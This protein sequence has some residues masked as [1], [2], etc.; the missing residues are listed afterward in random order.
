[1]KNVFL[2]LI[3]FTSI[4]NQAQTFGEIG[5]P[6]I[7][8]WS[9]K[10][11]EAHSQNWAI[12][13]DNRGIMYIGNS[14]GV[15]EFDGVSWRLLDYGESS[16][17]RSLAID[18]S[19][20]IFVGGKNEIGYFLPVNVFIKSNDGKNK[21]EKPFISLLKHIPQEYREFRDVWKTAITSKGVF[22]QTD[23][24]LFR[25]I[26]G[27]VKYEEG[28]IFVWQSKTGFAGMN[29]VDDRIYIA[30][31]GVGLMEVKGDSLELIRGGEKMESEIEFM[32]PISKSNVN[33]KILIGTVS[34]GLF[35]YDGIDCIPLEGEA[36]SF[37]KELKITSGLLLSDGTIAISTQ[38]C[39]I[40]IFDPVSGNIRN[41]FNK[42]SGLRDDVVHYLFTDRD[43]G[44]WAAHNSGIARLEVPSPF[45]F[46]DETHGLKGSPNVFLRYKNTL[47]IGTEIGL[48]YLNLY[49]KEFPGDAQYIGKNITLPQ[50]QF[51]PVTGLKNWVW[52]ITHVPGTNELLA[53]NGNDLYRIRGDKAEL[54]ISYTENIMTLHCSNKDPN[55][56]YIGLR[57]G[58]LATARFNPVNNTCL[59][60]GKI[61]GIDEYIKDIE[62]TE[63]GSLW[64]SAKYEK[65]LI[66]VKFLQM[67]SQTKQRDLSKPQIRRFGQA[68]GL[69]DLK[70]VYSIEINGQ[71]Y[72]YPGSVIYRF[73]NYKN[74]FILDST[75][76]ATPD[77]SVYIEIITE[78]KLG[79]IWFEFDRLLHVSKRKEDGSYKIESA[80]FRRIDRQVFMSIYPDNNG[81]I[82]YGDSDALIR[83]D[84]RVIKNYKEDVSAL[85]RRVIAG[86]DSI[87]FDGLPIVNEEV[88]SRLPFTYNTLLFKYSLPN[89]DNYKSNQYQY[90][91]EGFDSDWSSWTKATEKEYTN[92][93]QG[94][95]KFHVRGKNTY[96]FVSRES[97]YSFTIL[98]PWYLSWWA[99]TFYVLAI[100]LGIF[101]IDRIMRRKIINRERDRA[102]LRE[103]ELIKR[104]ADELEIVDR[105]VK[106]I[107]RAENLDQLFNSLLEQTFIVIPQGEK[108]AVFLLNKKEN[109][110]NI[111]Y[112]EGYE[113]KDLEKIAFTSE[114]LKT[115]YTKNSEEVEKGIYIIRNTD[116]LFGNDILFDFGKAKS[117]LVMAV[118]IDNLIE[119]YV[120]FDNYTE[121]NAFDSSTARLLNRFRE[122][123]V[124]AISKAQ[125]LK[126]LQEKN[127]EIVMTQ[128]QLIHS[129]K[130]ASL[131]ELTAGIAHEIK[132]P[133][134][135]VNNFS[136]VSKELLDEMKTE[137]QNDNKKE[138]LEIAEDLKHN[139]EKIIQ[140][141]RRADSIV[142]GMLLH[143]RGTS[144]EKVLTNINE[145]LDQF[146][147]LAYHGMRAQDK[148]FN[149]S[150]EKNYDESLEKINVI[151]Q[152]IS[153]VFL[154]LIN[155]ACYA[156]YDKING[157]GDNDFLPILKVSTKNLDG[158]IEIRISDNGNGVPANIVDKIFQPFFTTKPTGEGTGLG[159]SLSYDI[160]TKAHGG[161]LKVETKE[162]EG[163]EFIIILPKN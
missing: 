126:A 69:P 15:L 99:Y 59:D 3:L 146:V 127:D 129:E 159:L 106:V 133:L 13:Q 123:A 4:T 153:R 86:K 112:T 102:K 135:F 93:P 84:T 29:I 157:I 71:L 105:L 48:Y 17:T 77:T 108:A 67:N 96:D 156:A 6:F 141:G 74:I 134:N 97:V 79:N 152:D 43:G 100:I 144:G 50:P 147:T 12:I 39:G 25:Y 83:Y 139:L 63:D 98:P 26:P 163:S 2:I 160:V 54:L 52:D 113:I 118:E 53:S 137:L 111:A 23:K 114:E 88:Q 37:I 46:F 128:N 150:I 130:M 162:G 87:M 41:V 107:N 116:N 22:F 70:S 34:Y 117:M 148:E 101:I 119:A 143:S 57:Y 155:N 20:K 42:S 140:H 40:I 32:I 132:N 21:L 28:K 33:K 9:P 27:K 109:R 49:Q 64:L 85:I 149:I 14:S 125:A 16:F 161:E 56:V 51:K 95:Y 158:K 154:N 45:S 7:T 82:W 11:Y 89:Y 66:R 60:E 92:L 35:W 58:G 78:D 80:P 104:Q 121:S 75:F 38:N 94:D 55:R 151:P 124:S 65:Y 103:A 145:L 44:L 131:G 19:G 142:K 5:K 1:M 81:V 136:E 68:E 73:D 18:K 62:E 24:F 72:A 61:P 120:V 138:V 76:F 47:Y 91:L 8:N 31:Y 110:F 10:D 30:Q 115:R 122:H 90:F 36:A